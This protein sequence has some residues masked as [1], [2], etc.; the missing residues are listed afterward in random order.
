MITKQDLQA[1]LDKAERKVHTWSP[2]K[3]RTMELDVVKNQSILEEIAA[4][5]QAKLDSIPEDE[6][7]GRLA[8][9]CK[10]LQEIVTEIE[11]TEDQL[12]SLEKLARDYSD[13]LIPQAMSEI[14]MNNFTL[15]DGTRV[16]SVPFYN[17]SINKEN[18]EKAFYW[19]D[20]HGFGDLVKSQVVTNFGRTERADRLA[21]CQYLQ[22]QQLAFSAKDTVHPQ[23]LRAWAREQLEKGKALPPELFNTYVGQT[24][25]L[26]RKG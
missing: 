21:F 11:R 26:G 5:A 9:L 17:V 6:R 12:K 7:L 15:N 3:Q 25:K 22:T 2:Q 20:Q 16:S 14:G 24:T 13:H 8:N 18:E 1:E 23:T 10:T 19:L 4:D